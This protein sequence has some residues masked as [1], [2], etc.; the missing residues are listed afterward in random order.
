MTVSRV[1]ERFAFIKPYLMLLDR[2]ALRSRAGISMS[3]LTKVSLANGDTASS[4]VEECTFFFNKI[5]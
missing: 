1:G 5:Y 3:D 2:Q 4:P